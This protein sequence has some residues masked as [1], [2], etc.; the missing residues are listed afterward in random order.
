MYVYSYCNALSV[1]F[2]AVDKSLNSY[3][4][5]MIMIMTSWG[6]TPQPPPR[7]FKHCSILKSIHAF[8]ALTPA[9]ALCHYNKQISHRSL[10][11]NRRHSRTLPT[12]SC[13]DITG[14]NGERLMFGDSVELQWRTRDF[15][16]GAKSG[17][18]VLGEGHPAP[19]SPVRE[20]GERCKLPSR[21]LQ[22]AEPRPPSGFAY[23]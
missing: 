20:S 18:G 4:M 17:G 15:V 14:I 19:F 21:V 3:F 6:S 8:L 1:R 7:K 13:S 9:V 23:T 10:S 12:C 5:I 22:W 11:T 2:F 16:M